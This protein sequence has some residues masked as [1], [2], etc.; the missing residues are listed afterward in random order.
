[1]PYS[2]ALK[3]ALTERIG[4]FKTFKK[5]SKP[6]PKNINICF[7]TNFKSRLQKKRLTKDMYSFKRL[8]IQQTTQ[9]AVYCKKTVNKNKTKKGVSLQ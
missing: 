5:A 6:L 7:Q 9:E 3:K 2:K 1:M 4:T 8:R